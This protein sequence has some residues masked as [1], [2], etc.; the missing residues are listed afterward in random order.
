MLRSLVLFFNALNFY[1]IS[2]ETLYYRSSMYS[3]LDRL[4]YLLCHV[5]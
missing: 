1:R 2:I 5:N 3:P 4:I